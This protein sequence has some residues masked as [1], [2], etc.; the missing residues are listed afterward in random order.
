MGKKSGLFIR[1]SVIGLG[2]LTGL[3]TAIGISPQTVLLSIA[4]R[5][6]DVILHDPSVRFF[7]VLLP[8][9]L[10]VAAVITAYKGGR[11]IGLI[12]VVL[13]YCGGLVVLE[14]L[15]LSGIFLISAILLGFFATS[16]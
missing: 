5:S 1:E 14:S 12:S 6:A 4:E 11:V 7:F 16:R 10:L 8:I 9:I 3:W 15:N 13:A 2:F